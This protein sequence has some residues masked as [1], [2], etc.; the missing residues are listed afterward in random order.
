MFLV[1]ANADLGCLVLKLTSTW[2]SISNN[3]VDQDGDNSTTRT[4]IDA[5]GTLQKA[6]G[7][8]K[9]TENGLLFERAGNR[10]T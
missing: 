8:W 7:V 5:H 4:H 1:S 9:N 3:I 2:G 6:H 10:R